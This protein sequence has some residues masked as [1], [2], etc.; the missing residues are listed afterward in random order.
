[1][2][3]GNTHDVLVPLSWGH[4]VTQLEGIVEA[5]LV[6]EIQHDRVHAGAPVAFDQQHVFRGAVG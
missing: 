3:A 1:M 4:R 6:I 5:L 2:E